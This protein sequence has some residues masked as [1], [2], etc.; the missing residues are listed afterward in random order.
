MRRGSTCPDLVRNG[1]SFRGR[2]WALRLFLFDLLLR[3]G[4]RTAVGFSMPGPKPVVPTPTCKGAA[5][6]EVKWSAARTYL[7]D[8]AA[9]K[10]QNDSVDRL[11]TYNPN[12]DSSAGLRAQVSRAI[13]PDGSYAIVAKFWCNNLFECS[14]SA[15]G[16]NVV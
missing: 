15:L 3:G 7:I 13:Q 1:G 14:P 8:H 4:A 10:L 6:C 12:E 11:E 9:Y 16:G 2:V 5:D